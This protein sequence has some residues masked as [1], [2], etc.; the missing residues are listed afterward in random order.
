MS[1][2]MLK[3]ESEVEQGIYIGTHEIKDVEIL[4]VPRTVTFDFSYIPYQPGDKWHPSYDG[5]V[6]I[7]E[8]TVSRIE[9]SDYTP[10]GRWYP[11]DDEIR[12]IITDLFSSK[13][14]AIFE[15][16]ILKEIEEMERKELLAA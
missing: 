7:K 13:E 8:I 5:T 2:A 4:G 3:I 6:E 16:E 1:S 12:V 10:D 15:E 9:H 11:H 14:I